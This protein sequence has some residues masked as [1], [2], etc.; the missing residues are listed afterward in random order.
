MTDDMIRAWA[1]LDSIEESALAQLRNTAALPWVWKHVAVMPDVHFGI[2][3]DRGLGDRDEGRAWPG[4]RR[5]R[6]TAVTSSGR[7]S[8]RA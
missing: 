2:G 4:R 7:R 8:T 5:W 3:N 6:R 1:P